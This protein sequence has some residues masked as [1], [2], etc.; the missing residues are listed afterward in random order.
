MR[1]WASGWIAPSSVHPN[2][3][4]LGTVVLLG[5]Q[6]LRPTLSGV[7]GSLGIAGTVA[8]VTAGW[9]EREGEDEEPAADAPGARTERAG[10]SAR[11]YRTRRPM[12]HIGRVDLANA[13]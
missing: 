10:T 1:L 12:M 4:V 7:A 3:I 11:T 9:Q 5:P 6:R 13:A 2:A 8:V